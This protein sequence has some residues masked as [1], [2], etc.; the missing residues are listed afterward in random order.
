MDGVG[1]AVDFDGTWLRVRPTNI[2]ARGALGAKEVLLSNSDISSVSFKP[3]GMLSNGHLDVVSRGGQRYQLHFPRKQQKSFEELHRALSDVA[4]E[5]SVVP[6]RSRVGSTETLDTENSQSKL[7]AAAGGAPLLVRGTG[8]FGQEVVG[9]SNYGRQLAQ[10]AG[11]SQSGEREVTATLRRE[12]SNRYD[13]NAVQ[14]L[15]D[16]LLVGY[17]PREV[18]AAYQAPLQLI[19]KW[20]RTPVCKARVWWNRGYGDFMASVSLDLADPGELVPLTWPDARAPHVVVPP[21]KF[22]QVTGESEHMDVLAPLINRAYVPGKAVVYGT[23]HLEERARPRSTVQVV[24]VRV[25]DRE[26][27]ELSKQLSGRL[28]PLVNATDAAGLRCYV[29][30]LLTGNALAVEAKVGVTPPE[31]LPSEFVERLRGQPREG[32]PRV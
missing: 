31:E 21:A 10:L 6:S 12:P 13:N 26:I 14:V 28:L 15:I 19:E 16:D 3:A 4:S 27:G 29:E 9:E 11:R 30:V 25:E 18:A 20:N 22:Y 23:L 1:I 17:L 5:Q 24:A 7:T 8:Y 32:Q 2:V